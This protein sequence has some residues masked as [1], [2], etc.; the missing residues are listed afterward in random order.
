[1]PDRKGKKGKVTAMPATHKK[2]ARK[3]NKR[4][5]SPPSGVPMLSEPP[6]DS[7]TAHT[8]GTQDDRATMRDILMDIHSRLDSK[9]KDVDEL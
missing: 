6:S 2:K 9:Q 3:A 1:M 4:T 5:L 8:S 7:E